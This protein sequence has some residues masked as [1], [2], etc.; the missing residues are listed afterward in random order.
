MAGAKPRASKAVGWATDAAATATEE[1][2]E[3]EEPVV[4]DCDFDVSSGGDCRLWGSADDK[5]AVNTR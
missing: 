4:V 3:E 1:E 5:S 2:E